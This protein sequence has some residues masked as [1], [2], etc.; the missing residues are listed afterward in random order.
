MHLAKWQAAWQDAPLLLD[1]VN[2]RTL[3]APTIKEAGR[4]TVQAPKGP[5]VDEQ[6]RT[7]ST[8]VVGALHLG[9]G[10]LVG[11]SP[12]QADVR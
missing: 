12:S 1:V 7:S 6:L 5:V 4:E 3:H 2:E 10:Q 9:N 11:S 8:A